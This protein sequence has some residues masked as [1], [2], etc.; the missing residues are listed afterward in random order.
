VLER[1][2]G[3][4][5]NHM[6]WEAGEEGGRP[7]SRNAE[8]R[9]AQ[10]EDNLEGTETPAGTKPKVVQLGGKKASA[11]LVKSE[12]FPR[13]HCQREDCLMCWQEV[14]KGKEGSKGK[15]FKGGCGYHGFCTRCPKEHLEAGAVPG[16]ERQAL[17]QDETHKTSYRRILQHLAEYRNRKDRSWMWDHVRNKHEEIMGWEGRGGME[18]FIFNVTGETGA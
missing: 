11:D 17:Y 14:R 2:Q 6:K 13:A 15:C 3:E 7:S 4:I 1:F 10:K 18:D 12:A 16:T 9:K 5:D 8:E